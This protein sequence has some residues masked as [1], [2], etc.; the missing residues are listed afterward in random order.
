MHLSYSSI[1]DFKFCPNYYRLTRIEKLR[2]FTG[3]IYTAFGKAVHSAC[4]QSVLRR[5]KKFN[6]LSY[7][8]K[9]FTKE[10]SLLEEE[11][12]EK[13]KSEFSQSAYKVLEPLLSFMEEKFGNYEVISTEKSLRSPVELDADIVGE[14]DFLG[15]ENYILAF[16]RGSWSSETDLI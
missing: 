2:P 8:D 15:Y 1:K 9:E 6:S 4:E 13:Q 12:S 16:N 7:F 3:N 11:I 5:D 10:I 14:Y